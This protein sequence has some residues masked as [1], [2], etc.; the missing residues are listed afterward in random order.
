M[1]FSIRYGSGRNAIIFS[2]ILLV[3]TENLSG[4]IIHAAYW[5]LADIILPEKN[6]SDQTYNCSRD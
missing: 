2:G 6:Y 4:W 5:I 3:G 1:Q